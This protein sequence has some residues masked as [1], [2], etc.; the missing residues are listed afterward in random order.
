MM[1]RRLCGHRGKRDMS[2]WR[3]SRG[4][5]PPESALGSR[6]SRGERS[7]EQRQGSSVHH[8]FLFDSEQFS[9]AGTLSPHQGH[10]IRASWPHRQGAPGP[11]SVTLHSAWSV[12]MLI[13]SRLSPQP[14]WGGP[15]GSSTKQEVFI[16]TSRLCW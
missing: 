12:K 8:F 9:T 4:L 2:Q 14:G 6:Q 1:R 3:V 7:H 16:F 10:L 11:P 5:E 15:H 13:G